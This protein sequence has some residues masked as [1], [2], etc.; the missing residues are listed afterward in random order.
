MENEYA[1]LTPASVHVS[2]LGKGPSSSFVLIEVFQRS[3]PL[4]H[5]LRLVNT[6]PSHMPQVFEVL[7]L[8]CKVGTQFLPALQALPVPSP[9]I[10]T[11]L[12]G[13]SH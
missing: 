1:V 4:Q 7:F 12:G 2:R 13:K 8:C 9:L 10:F 3:L 5:R 6:S 11:V